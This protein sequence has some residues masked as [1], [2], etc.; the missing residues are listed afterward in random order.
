[1]HATMFKPNVIT[2]VRI[3][4]AK[5]YSKPKFTLIKVRM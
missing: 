1:M 3:P 2:Q 4:D 5:N